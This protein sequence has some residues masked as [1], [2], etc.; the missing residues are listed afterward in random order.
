MLKAYP[1]SK[2]TVSYCKNNFIWFCEVIKKN[3][4]EV[5]EKRL[6]INHEVVSHKLQQHPIPVNKIKAATEVNDFD[7]AVTSTY[8]SAILLPKDD[9]KASFKTE[10]TSG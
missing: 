8:S 5:P 2:Y 10:I 1:T 4:E 6:R 3:A 9:T 7:V